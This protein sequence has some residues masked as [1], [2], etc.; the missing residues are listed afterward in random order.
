MDVEKVSITVIGIGGIG[1]K[2]LY[3]TLPEFLSGRFRDALVTITL[4]DGDSYEDRNRDRQH[5]HR[6]GN[7]AEV[8]AEAL[9]AHFTDIVFQSEKHYVTEANIVLRVGEGDIVFLCVDNHATRRLVSKRCEEL[10]NVALISGGNDVTDGNVQVFVRKNG[11]SVTAPLTK[12]HPEI[13]DPKDKRPDEV[14]CAA[15]AAGG[16]TQIAITNNDIAAAM[17]NAFY[18]YCEGKLAY[19]EVYCDVVKNSRKAHPRLP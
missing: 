12:Y 17:L 14:G 15:L 4:V 9:A 8:A 2:L 19:G 18:A 11:V 6:A 3:Y 13:A 10:Q 16:N 7:K 1:T 5:F